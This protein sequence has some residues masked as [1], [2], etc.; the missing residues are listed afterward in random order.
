MCSTWR[1]AARSA[2]GR[3]LTQRGGASRAQALSP[4]AARAQAL[5]RLAP[6]PLLAS[7]RATPRRPQPLSASRLAPRLRPQRAAANATRG[8]TTPAA[9][10]RQSDAVVVLHPRARAFFP[11]TDS[12]PEMM[13]SVR[14]V[15][16]TMASYVSSMAARGRARQKN[17]LNGFRAR[18]GTSIV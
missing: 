7:T 14:P 13:H 9:A 1:R 15:P 10:R 11:A 5:R 16:S 6:R 12:R 2:R 18:I 17:V 3:Q 8:D 4:P